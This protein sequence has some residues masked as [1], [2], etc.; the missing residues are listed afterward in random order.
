MRNV[1]FLLLVAMHLC[2]CFY[3]SSY[4]THCLNGSVTCKVSLPLTPFLC[5][6]LVFNFTS[7]QEIGHSLKEFLPVNLGLAG[8]D[9]SNLW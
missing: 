6:S 8:V 3:I 1:I 2:T 9:S 4:T 7:A 5:L